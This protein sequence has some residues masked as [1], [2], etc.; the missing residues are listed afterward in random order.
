MEKEGLIK[1]QKEISKGGRVSKY[2]SVTPLGVKTLEELII[3]TPSD[4]P[5]QF[6]ANS[7]IKLICS[8]I[9]NNEKKLMLF[10]ALKSKAQGIMLDVN[11][12]LKNENQDF[13][14]R[15][16]YDNLVCEYRNFIILLEGFESACKN[17]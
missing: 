3:E 16:V 12:L 5:V 14:K 4:N 1:S 9:L 10:R 2:Y 11:N 7:R 17:K 6:L 13:Y 8:N 15:M